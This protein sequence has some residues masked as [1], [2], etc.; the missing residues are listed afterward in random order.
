VFFNEILRS[1][2]E[3]HDGRRITYEGSE[4]LHFDS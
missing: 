4:W 3:L 1:M 2:T